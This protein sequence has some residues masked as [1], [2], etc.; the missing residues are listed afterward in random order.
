MPVP[1]PVCLPFPRPR[2]DEATLER[3]ICAYLQHMQV[4]SLRGKL[5]PAHLDNVNRS[6]RGL[7][8]AWRVVFEDGR[9]AILPAAIA[10]ATPTRWPR[11]PPPRTAADQ[12]EA[13]AWAIELF[14]GPAASAHAA[15]NGDTLIADA[16]NDDLEL[17]LLANP[18]WRTQNAQANVVAAIVNCFSWYDDSKGVR[19]PYRRRLAPKFHRET[20]REATQDEYERMVSR[21]CSEALYL[22]LWCLWHVD[23]IRTCELYA[24]R[25]TH[26]KDRGEHNSTLEV[27][28]KSQRFTGKLKIIPLTPRTREFFVELHR[29]RVDDIVFHNTH[30]TA[31]N[32]HSFDHHFQ[33]RRDALGLSPTL[34][35]YC[36]R[37]SFATDAVVARAD[38]A[39]VAALLGHS[40]TRM[41]DTVYSKAEQK[42]EHMCSVAREVEAKV[43]AL[44]ESRRPKIGEAVQG[45]LFEP[46]CVS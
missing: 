10:V 45:E 34:T 8:D 7:A 17:W 35:P 46:P 29:T 18:Q 14:P 27:P 43:Q 23:G 2:A 28:H 32:R 12:A 41:L 9:Q 31:W 37:H 30:G 3:A 25:W 11:R 42:T 33:R 26:F 15:R 16:S 22:A 39:D 40:S 44:R 19:S 13:I 38:K 36:L 5:S 21:G 4:K 24:L 1:S 6:L 20:R